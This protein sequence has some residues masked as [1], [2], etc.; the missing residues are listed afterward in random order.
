LQSLPQLTVDLRA[1]PKHLLLCSGRVWRLFDG[2]VWRLF[3]GRVW[4]LFEGVALPAFLVKSIAA[5]PRI[6]QTRCSHRDE[7]QGGHTLEKTGAAHI[8]TINTARPA[9]GPQ[10]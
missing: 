6:V 8:H 1:E 3:D 9:D 10:G 2:R 4:L 5:A 7:P